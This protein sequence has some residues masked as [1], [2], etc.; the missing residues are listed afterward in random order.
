[1]LIIDQ[2]LDGVNT[3]ANER[4]PVYRFSLGGSFAQLRGC[5]GARPRGNGSSRGKV[6]GFSRRS[7]K[8]L[9]DW[10]NQIDRR[11]VTDS[12]FV[13]LTYPSEWP[14]DWQVWKRH[15]STF[16]KRLRRLSPRAAVVWRQEFQ[17]RGAPHYHLIVFNV[18]YLS[19]TWVAKAWYDVVGS[20][21]PRHLAAGVE[22]RRVRSFRAAIGYASK[23]LA[24]VSVEEC[25]AG[26]SETGRMWGVFGREFLPVQMVQVVLDWAQFYGMR[27]L[28]RR[29]LEGKLLHR[30][31]YARLKGVG[32]TCYFDADTAM[33]VLASTL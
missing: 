21:D 11:C 17:K 10:L 3:E 16:L 32:I 7:R 14:A 30:V 9:L 31:D 22:V 18:G 13:T 28:M 23:Y 15:L 5:R 19:H 25:A 4:L 33:M 8:R 24:K 26:G 27:R 2:V 6:R 20:G 29:W 1:L 12:I